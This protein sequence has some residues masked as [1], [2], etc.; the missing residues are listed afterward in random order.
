[1]THKLLFK[2]KYIQNETGKTTTILNLQSA[3]EKNTYQKHYIKNMNVIN[4]YMASY[5]WNLEIAFNALWLN[6]ID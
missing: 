6:S 5:N 2:L 1:M 3:V 4:F